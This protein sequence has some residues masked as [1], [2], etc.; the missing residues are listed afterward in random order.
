V[1]VSDQDDDIETAQ[2]IG[3][4]RELIDALDGRLPHLERAGETHIAAD[5]AA[6]KEKAMQR[7]AELKDSKLI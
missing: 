6:L 2:L 1:D 4:L 3:R 7:I 5:A